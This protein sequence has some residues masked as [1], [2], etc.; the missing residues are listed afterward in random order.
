[1]GSAP[2]GATVT[3]SYDA[4]DDTLIQPGDFLRTRAGR[5]YR[6]LG[7]R[8]VRGKYPHRWRLLL[9]VIEEIPHARDDDPNAMVH[10]LVFYPR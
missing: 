1:M 3:I 4:S 7:S 9:V 8:R 10:P 5:A 2:V 6:V